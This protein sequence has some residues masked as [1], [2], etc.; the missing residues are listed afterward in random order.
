MKLPSIVYFLVLFYSAANGQ[1][2]SGSGGPI[3]DDGN[4]NYFVLNVTGLSPATLTN[5]H[6]LVELCFNITHTWDSDVHAELI[7]PD[8]TVVELFN[9]VGGDGDDFQ[10]TCLNDNSATPISSGS[11]PFSGTFQPASMLGN[12]NNGSDGNGDWTLKI[13][14]TY[15]FA[16]AGTLL[17]CELRFDS[18][19]TGQFSLDSTHLPIF[20]INTNG[21]TIEDEPKILVNLKVINYGPLQYNQPN[22]FPNEYNGNIGIE[23]RGQSSMG[24]PKKSYG[25]ETR[26]INGMDMD[27]SLLGLPPEEDWILHAPY[28]DKSLL[29]NALAMELGNSMGHYNSNTRF[30]ELIMNGEYMGVYVLMEKIKKDN[31][32]VALSTLTTADTIGDELT[33]GYLFRIDKGNDPGWYSNYDIYSLPGTKIRFQYIY[34]KGDDI[35]PS[36]ASYI[37][38]YVDSFENALASSDLHDDYGNRYDA[39]IDLES[40]ADYFILKELAKDVDAYRISSYFHKDKNSNGGKLKASPYWDFN[41]AFHNADYCNGDDFTGW[42]YDIHCDDGNPFWW[43][44]ML[45]DSVFTNILACRWTELR[46]SIFESSLLQSKVD[47]MANILDQAQQRNFQ[48]WPI[49][50][51]WVWPN[52]WPLSNSYTEEI[53]RIKDWMTNRTSWMDVSL[54]DTCIAV[55]PTSTNYT[56]TFPLKVYPNPVVNK[57]Y[58]SGDINQAKIQLYQYNGQSV[59]MKSILNRPE[60]TIDFSKLAKGMYIL[61]ISGNNKTTYF[62]KIIFN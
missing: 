46:S 48:R 24:F 21:Q 38:S 28:S 57:L 19:A 26:D 41:L 9:G 43:N 4:P 44:K 18:S 14:D 36:Q 39:F 49:W 31:N 23:L 40:F 17:D 35:L 61:E 8:G 54:N 3:T 37:Q 60:Q 13:T 12:V 29:R 5:S 56:A 59:L 10:N 27:V 53:A 33:G 42:M 2:F 45:N 22:D 6:G 51:T 62:S 11:A 50:G 55:P 32:R 30:I 7:A 34:P 20:I 15:P 25:I 58:I 1:T 16:D 47:S 52:P